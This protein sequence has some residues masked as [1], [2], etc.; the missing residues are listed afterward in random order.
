M[1]LRRMFN[2]PVALVWICLLESQ[3]KVFSISMKRIRSD[4]NSE[5]AVAIE[6][7]NL[8]NKMKITR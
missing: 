8:S 7:D 4:S 2:D 1:V 5:S 6:L 3:M